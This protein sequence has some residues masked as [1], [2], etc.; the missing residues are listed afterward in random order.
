[1]NIVHVKEGGCIWMK[2]ADFIEHA[3]GNSSRHL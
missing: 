2:R 1:M 3:I